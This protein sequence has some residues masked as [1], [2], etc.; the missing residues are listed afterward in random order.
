ME[1][2]YIAALCAANQIGGRRI[3]LLTKFFGSAK[4][5]WQAEKIDLESSGLPTNALESLLLFRQ[6]FPYA[7]EKLIEFCAAKKIGLCSI[8][9]EDYPPILK[10]ISSPPAV[11]YYRGN[12]KPF[13]ER[14]AMVGT[15]DNTAYG[16]QV[17][18]TLGEDL[19]KAGLTVVSGAARG[20][21]IFAH[22]GAL[23]FG[24]TVAVLGC[25]INFYKPSEPKQKLLEEIAEQGLVMTEFEPRTP[26]NP[27]TFP[28]R[29]RIIAG[30]CKGV[31]VVEAGEKSGALITVD[32]ALDSGRDVFAVPG[33]IFSQKS[34]GCHNLI[35][36][37]AVL[38]TSAQDILDAY[39]FVAKNNFESPP[40]ALDESQKKVLNLMPLGSEISAD[41][42]LMQT[43]EV[44]PD[45]ISEILLQLELKNF[46][47][48][49]DL[50]YLRIK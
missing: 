13:A 42:I 6:E 24:R 23:K 17:A 46:I 14:I 39:Q 26:P 18:I 19:A 28:Q 44:S 32:S 4:A 1:K 8:F 3:K 30:L 45:E 36:E 48:E 27:K 21:D 34:V 9:D 35:R 12:L 50:G 2:Y 37:G 47:Q 20:I 15:R 7:P 40:V 41:E 29:N 31:V 25:G 38:V 11:F 16:K 5:A 22:T 10:E 43:N 33:S 49:S